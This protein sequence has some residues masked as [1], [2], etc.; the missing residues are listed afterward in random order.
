MFCIFSYFWCQNG[1]ASRGTCTQGLYYNDA[2]KQCDD[3]KNVQCNIIPQKQ[4]ELA[5]VVITCPPT[6]THFYPHPSD[7]GHY[8]ICVNGANTLLNCGPALHYDFERQ[9]C[10]TPS[11]TK[12]IVNYL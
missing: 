1:I 9:L 11:N 8:F 4:P 12:C 5:D 10:D 2:N 6:G 7:C 3:P